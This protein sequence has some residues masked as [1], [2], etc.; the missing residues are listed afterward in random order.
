MPTTSLEAIRVRAENARLREAVLRQVENIERWI[1]T[2]VPA[3]ADE[4]KSIYDQL[5][6]ALKENDQ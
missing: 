6:T 5:R 4:S 3:D 2:G 1:E